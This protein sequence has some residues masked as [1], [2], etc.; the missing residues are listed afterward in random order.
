MTI[1]ENERYPQNLIGALGIGPIADDDAF[2]GILNKIK[3]NVL[4]DIECQV[5]DYR[6]KQNM[7]FRQTAELLGF[8]H[9][10]IHQIS[11]RAL[12]KIKTEYDAGQKIQPQPVSGLNL[13][14][15][16]LPYRVIHLLNER[17]IYSTD[18]LL[19]KTDK[20]LLSIPTF[21]VKSLSQLDA[22][23][24]QNGFHRFKPSLYDAI[25]DVLKD[26]KLD[27]GQLIEKLQKMSAGGNKGL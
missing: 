14:K 2:L 21:G 6:Y 11:A 1:I 23:L 19:T 12:T 4:S 24:T 22:A 27:I 10:R 7:T 16:H 13:S 17:G 15:L 26:F 9:Q 8:S 5:I 18:Q 3:F 25:N 20:D